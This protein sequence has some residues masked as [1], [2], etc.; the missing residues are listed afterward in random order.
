M[1]GLTLKSRPG[2]EAAQ[3]NSC[4]QVFMQA[5]AQVFVRG[6]TGLMTT[7]MP[8]L[9]ATRRLTTPWLRYIIP[10]AVLGILLS[11]LEPHLHTGFLVKAFRGPYSGI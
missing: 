4:R 2:L 10:P 6:H 11:C 5:E 9:A 7:T 8:A 1:K 3:G